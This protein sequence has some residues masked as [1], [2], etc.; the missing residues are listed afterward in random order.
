MCRVMEDFG[1]LWGDKSR[2][3]RISYSF[4][5]RSFFVWLVVLCFEGFLES[6]GVFLDEKCLGFSW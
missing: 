4:V 5:L 6:R 3:G 1:G 2:E